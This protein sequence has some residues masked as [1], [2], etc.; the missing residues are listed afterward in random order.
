MIPAKRTE[1]IGDATLYLGDC[2]EILP[3]LGKVDHII[4]DP[5]YEELMQYL[6]NGVKL[7]RTDGG[8]ARRALDFASIQC[9]REPFLDEVRRINGGWLLAFCNVEGVWHW[10][11]AITKRALKFKTTCIWHKPDATPK[12][13]GQG[14]ALAYE[15]IT[16][17][18]CGR[19]HARWNGGGRRGV[20]PY[21]TNN[22][23]RHGGHPT[24]KPV[25]LMREL[26]ALFSNRDETILDPFMGSGTTGVACAKLGRKF[27]GI[28]IEPKYFDI[29]CKRIE[30]AYKQLDMF[31]APPPKMK[32]EGMDI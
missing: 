14:P 5:P 6:H 8:S 12:L 1:Q 10:R 25:A 11:D 23:E 17:T 32:Q 2:L 16:T 27:I 4:S 7:R 9:I 28:E 31:I 24:E 20:F 19:G 3:Q 26:V 22:A 15:C 21:C 18:W 30:D 13:N 29:A